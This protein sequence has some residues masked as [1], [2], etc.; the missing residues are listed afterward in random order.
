MD[1]LG[2]DR[3]WVGYLPSLIHADP[4]AGNRTLQKICAPHRD[5]L[6]P[7]PTLN[8]EQPR[9][10]DDL[11]NALA[12]G[13]PA[14]RLFPQ[15]Q[16]LDPAGDA[17]RV[18][19]AAAAVAGIPILLAV[20][21][22]DSRQRHP[23]DRAPELTAAAVRTLVREDSELRVLVTHADRTFVE[24]VHFGLTTAEASRVLWDISWIWGP[25]EDHLGLLFDTV[26]VERFAF[27]TGMPLR[28]GD[29]ALA[30]LDVL[31]LAEEARRGV[32]GRHVTEWTAATT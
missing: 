25:P 13:A 23:A 15:Y 16:G 17:M 19:T 32:L 2:I 14:L 8:P 20:R 4:S 31:D 26:G 7:V 21:L 30:K 29:A 9:W 18:V 12:V 11:N 27:G 6:L 24:E 10:H 1:R 3:A 5:R 28:I 22:E